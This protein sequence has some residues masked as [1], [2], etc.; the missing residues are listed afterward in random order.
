MSLVVDYAIN[1]ESSDAT[2]EPKQQAML[3]QHHYE[4][5]SLAQCHCNLSLLD[6]GQ[7]SHQISPKTCANH[8]TIYMLHSKYFLHPHKPSGGC[9]SKLSAA[10]T[11]HVQQLISSWKAVNAAKNAKTLVYAKNQPLTSYNIHFTPKQADL[12][13]MLKKE[14]HF[15]ASGI[16]GC[17]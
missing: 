14:S 2:S 3:A 11:H 12:R 15:S 5:S 10:D 9:S 13:A 16:W 17:S 7:L 1:R 6:A 8:S 4:S